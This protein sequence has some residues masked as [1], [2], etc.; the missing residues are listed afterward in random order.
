ECKPVSSTGT[1]KANKENIQQLK[2]GLANITGKYEEIRTDYGAAIQQHEQIRA[3]DQATIQ[4]PKQ[5]LAHANAANEETRTR[6]AESEAARAKDKATIERPEQHIEQT[7]ADDNAL[8]ERIQRDYMY[9]TIAHEHDRVDDCE[10]FEQEREDDWAMFKQASDADWAMF[11]QAKQDFGRKNATNKQVRANHCTKIQQLEQD[12]AHATAANNQTCTRAVKLKATR[13]ND[14]AMIQQVN[15]VLIDAE[16]VYAPKYDKA[17][18]EISG[19][20]RD[21][22]ERNICIGS[23]MTNCILAENKVAALQVQLKKAEK[24]MTTEHTT[25]MHMLGIIRKA[26][27]DL[28]VTRKDAET[29][30][31]LALELAKCGCRTPDSQI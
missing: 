9:A 2:M 3:D 6:T 30:R 8:I 4:Q 12:L 7:N 31:Q 21:L 27:H 18:E 11:E 5:D 25:N 23:L 29:E 17:M 13:A 28:D 14:N 19:L 16:T 10:M 1:K 22:A 20:R 24:Q 26:G 15:Q